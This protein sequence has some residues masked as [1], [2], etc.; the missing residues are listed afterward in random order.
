MF[1]GSKKKNPERGRIYN[2]IL[3]KR[4]IRIIYGG[5]NKSAFMYRG[6]KAETSVKS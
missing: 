5:A 6:N 4:G 2:S 3:L 1:D